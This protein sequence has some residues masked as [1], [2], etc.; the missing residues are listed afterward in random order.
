MMRRLLVI[1]ALI[2]PALVLVFFWLRPQAD[3]VYALPLFHF[4]IV[5]FTT[6]AAAVVSLLLTRALGLVAQARH[7]LAA[8]AFAV[9]GTI[10][11]VHG[12]TTPG[13][14]VGAD[15]PVVVAVSWSAWLTL[16]A[17]GA[18]FA[19][20]GLDRPGRELSRRH[21]RQITTITAIGVLLY[22][23]LVL[24]APGW[25]SAINGRVDPWHRHLLFFL[26]LLVWA[27]AALLFW[28]TWRITLSRV[29]GTLVFVAGWMFIATI[30][31]HRF[32]VWHLSWWL[33]HFLLLLSFLITIFVLAT[34]YEQARQFRLVDYYL[35]VSLIVT[36]ALTLLASYL[37]TEFAQRVLSEEITQTPQLAAR[38]MLVR[39]AGLAIS[40]LTMGLL[41]ISLLQ[42]VIRADRIITTRTQELSLINRN[43]RRAEAL[44]DD[45]MHMIIHDLRTPLTTIAAGLGLLAQVLDAQL[46]PV[47]ERV[48]ARTSRAAHRLDR[49]IDDILMVSKIE[50]GELRPRIEKVVLSDLLQEWLDVFTVQAQAEEKTLTLDCPPGLSASLDPKLTGRVVENLVGNAMKYTNSGGH[51]T[52]SA[53]SEDGAI[54]LSVRDDGEGVPDDYKSYIFQKFSQGPADEAHSVRKGTG[55]GLAFCRL[56]VESHGGSIWVEDAPGGGSDFK[57]RLPVAAG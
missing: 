40:A 53:H 34:A 5:T 2:A 36:V 23:L 50:T 19:L 18:V 30:S 42:I 54:C 55:L 43:L 56:V 28:R 14:L 39:R 21:H 44:R 26:T 29:D 31:L 3:S 22:L 32:P 45:L 9:M 49:M 47:Q 35:A 15:N 27:T 52:I 12:A 7:V 41:F 37:F 46:G 48:L 10:F 25:L 51:I 38:V 17:G 24:L 8:A 13:A 1:A 20:A 16:F 4:Y 33:Y 6:F 11:F 57:V